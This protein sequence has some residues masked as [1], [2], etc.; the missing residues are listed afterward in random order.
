MGIYTN[1]VI[2]RADN[3]NNIITL[4]TEKYETIMNDKQMREVYLFYTDR[5][6]NNVIIIW[7]KY[8]RI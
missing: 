5:C 8:I 2:Y 3:D 4:F 1:G 6:N 7:I